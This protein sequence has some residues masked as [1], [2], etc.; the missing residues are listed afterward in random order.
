MLR[1]SYGKA[2]LSGNIGQGWQASRTH[3][4]TDAGDQIAHE[5]LLG[6]VVGVRPAR[7]LDPQGMLAGRAGPDQLR[8][9]QLTVSDLDQRRRRRADHASEKRLEFGFTLWS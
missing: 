3:H 2:A 9:D 8:P 4:C 5:L 1:R 6:F 7:I